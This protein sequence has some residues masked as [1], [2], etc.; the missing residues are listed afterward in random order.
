[1][2]IKPETENALNEL[3]EGVMLQIND[4]F[5]GLT[6]RPG[7]KCKKCGWEIGSIGFPPAHDC[8]RDGENQQIARGIINSYKLAD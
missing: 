3:F 1:M 8:P 7:W 2:L 5:I 6:N 4:P